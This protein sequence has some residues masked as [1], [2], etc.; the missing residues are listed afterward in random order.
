MS[1][2]VVGWT[3]LAAILAGIGDASAQ[4]LELNGSVDVSAVQAEIN[5]DDQNTL[6]QRYTVNATR[7]LTEA[8]RARASFRYFKF[9]LDQAEQLG[10][11]REE[12]Q[13]SAE[14]SWQQ[15]LWHASVTGQRRSVRTQFSNGRLITDSFVA[16][17]R[18]RSNEW[19]IFSVRYDWQQIGDTG[20]VSTRDSR[21]ARLVARV[22]VERDHETIDYTFTHRSSSNLLRD[23]ESR[24]ISHQLRL[25]G[26]HRLDDAARWRLDTQYLFTR[27]DRTDEVRQ[28]AVLLEEVSVANGLFAI[29]PAPDLGELDPLPGLNDGNTGAATSPLVEIGAGAV[30][31]NIG[32]DL[33]LERAAVAGFF[34]YVDRVSSATLN[35]TVYVSD[36]GLNWSEVTSAPVTRFNPAFLR[37]EIEFPPV[38]GRL[39]KVVNGGVN[40]A[41]GVSVTEI[42]VFEAIQETG[43]VERA[44][45]THLANASLAWRPS[46]GFDATLIGTARLEPQQGSV[47][48]RESYDYA[49][50]GR[51]RQ[52]DDVQ[53]V[54]RWEQA[55]QRFESGRASLRDDVLAGTFLYD[56]LPTLGT[57]ASATWRRAV[58]GGQELRT[59]R[60][61]FAS[62]DTEPIAALDVVVDAVVSRL[63]DP[64]TDQSNDVWTLRSSLDAEVTRSLRVLGSWAHQETRTRPSDD[65]VIRRTWTVDVDLQFTE[66]IFARV[67]TTWVEDQR[68]SRRQDYLLNWRVGPRL[69]L[70]GQ[71]IYDDASGGFRTD[72]MSFS[73]TF[74]VNRR[75]TAYL[76]YAELEQSAVDEQRTM[77]WQQGLRMT[78]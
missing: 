5:G 41:A 7:R 37:Y 6:Q 16:D 70:T 28:G 46:A 15:R 17:W 60:S 74:D 3:L 27:S 77:S 33:G 23:L 55:W 20:D 75:T 65:L 62:V 32:A 21:D 11:F 49:A 78:F 36:D 45:T 66:R 38:A 47:G 25:L 69:V 14:V 1:R 43:E 34:V 31:R 13:P 76:R 2:V 29:D 4:L 59:I 68:F 67:G 18:T 63:D 51:W 30:D 48:D 35:W 24:E 73:A 44:S 54:G 61:A 9:D 8:L 50:R 26:S 42:E 10:V 64:L 57:T 19:P 12:F 58:E 40:D 52:T 71:A 39:V 72:R 53:W 22:D 56:P